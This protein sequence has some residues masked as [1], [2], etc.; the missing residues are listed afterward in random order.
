MKIFLLETI[1]NVG[2]IG[3]R[4]DVKPGYARN[5]LIPMGKAALATAENVA[6]FEQLRAERDKQAQ[7]EVE[8]ARARA[9]VLDGQ[10]VRIAARAGSEGKLFG[11]VGT[12]DIAAACEALGVKI[13][14]SRIRMPDGPLRLVG[15]HT[16]VLH[17]HAQVDVPL[18]VVVESSEAVEAVADADKSADS[19]DSGDAG[20][21]AAGEQGRD[22]SEPA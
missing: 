2:R 3:D 4:V 16:V 8:A 10:V 12:I 17:L 20:T 15:E 1:N 7:T 6:R 11:S 14:R 13:E 5:Y 21:A 18:K 19:P 9:Q 22:A